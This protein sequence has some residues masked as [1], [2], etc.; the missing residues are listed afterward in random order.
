M[1]F[2]DAQIKTGKTRTGTRQTNSS[3]SPHIIIEITHGQD[4]IETKRV[5]LQP[6]YYAFMS[7]FN[8]FFVISIN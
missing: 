1:R 8:D 6:H 5:L 4:R 2:E 7:V 3:V